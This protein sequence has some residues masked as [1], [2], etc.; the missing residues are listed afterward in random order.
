MLKGGVYFKRKNKPPLQWFV[1]FL[2]IFSVCALFFLFRN[3]TT[4]TRSPHS[5]LE[6]GPLNLNQDNLQQAIT[7]LETCA[8]T[9]DPKSDRKELG[10]VEFNIGLGLFHI[11]KYHESIPHLQK[12]ITLDSET[13]YRHQAN[14]MKMLGLSNSAI[15]FYEKS[16]G[17][18]Q[19]EIELR[20]LDRDK[21]SQVHA[22]SNKARVCIYLNL[23]HDSEKALG[24]ASNIL[25]TVDNQLEQGRVN[26]GYGR[27]YNYLN[28]P[29]NAKEKLKVAEK[30]CWSAGKI[31]YPSL[32]AEV[33]W[34]LAG[35]HHEKGDYSGELDLL[36]SAEKFAVN[37]LESPTLLFRI[38]VERA[39]AYKNLNKFDEALDLLH[40][41][42][43]ELEAH[44][45][46]RYEILT[47]AAIADTYRRMAKLEN[48][49]E[50]SKEAYKLAQ[51]QEDRLLRAQM[52]YDLALYL[53]ELGQLEMASTRFSEAA[54]DYE[55]ARNDL[56]DFDSRRRFVGSL[57]MIYANWAALQ[58]YQN[59]IREAFEIVE[60]GRAKAL[61]DLF[62]GARG[63]QSTKIEE[64]DLSQK[65]RADVSAVNYSELTSFLDESVTLVEYFHPGA[66]KVN[67]ETHEELWIFVVKKTD[68]EL[69]RV[70]I[71]EAILTRTLYQF[72][73]GFHNPYQ[74]IR[75]SETTLARWF[76]DPVID[77][78]K[79]KN[80]LIVPWKG[81]F[82]MPLPALWN[83]AMPTLNVSIAPS[84]LSMKYI[85]E[86]KRSEHNAAVIFA[87][88]A[89]VSRLAAAEV[90]GTRLSRYFP[91]SELLIGDNASE[92]AVK[93]IKTPP[94]ILHFAS[95][96]YFDLL[97][98]FQSALKLTPDSV[99]DGDLQL[100]EIY[101][102]KLRGVSIVSL[103]A[104]DSGVVQVYYGEELLG[105]VQAFLLAG[106]PSVI[107][108]LWAVDDNATEEFM[109]EF[110]R[111][112][113]S[114]STKAQAFRIA[115]QHVAAQPE[116]RTPFFWASFQLYG[117]W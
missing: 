61:I 18:F 56:P 99:N 19:K 22:L 62:E 38:K 87:N 103:G 12:S 43:P 28:R 33:Y 108:S 102:L 3:H 53:M 5:C 107:A 59:H 29:E 67:G 20:I 89:N 85:L 55:R 66:M 41:T 57:P 36:K 73:I 49:V 81:T 110:Y 113:T 11:S 14:I 24:E 31:L 98:P 83:S 109:T 75:W 76:L 26:L 23:Y 17:Y 88:P 70:P 37:D 30:E 68:I 106:S 39:R 105:L 101:N 44:Q 32:L 60:R 115:Q 69:V 71:S 86:N 48:A 78:V 9:L 65:I 16:L 7:K 117:Q 6:R 91:K 2:G 92:T 63:S 111:E 25:K 42:L 46:I 54:S 93:N 1:L 82:L 79:T 58:I 35:L 52:S 72:F 50:P 15:G 27:L 80:L 64:N 8:S 112:Y 77:K 104:C 47:H 51:E 114:G 21:V 96:G 10:K 13:N 100:A 97:N 74:T 116:W 45:D 94:D 34:N 4:P 95:H 84:A 40:E 90:E